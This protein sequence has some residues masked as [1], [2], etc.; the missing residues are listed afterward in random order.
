M[1]CKDCYEGKDTEIIQWASEKIAN[2]N[3]PIGKNLPLSGKTLK[4]LNS[5]ISFY[6]KKYGDVLLE[7]PEV[8]KIYYLSKKS[9][10]SEEALQ[11]LDYMISHSII[12]DKISNLLNNVSNNID[13]QQYMS[14]QHPNITNYKD[15][16]FDINV[17]PSYS[18]DVNGFTITITPSDEF[19]EYAKRKYPEIDSVWDQM[20]RTPHHFGYLAYARCAYQQGKNLV[21]NNL[22]R[23][24]DFDN[25]I[26]Q[27]GRLHASNKKREMAKWL[28]SMTKNW[29]V[30]LLH[31]VKSLAIKEDINAFL[32]TFDQ[33]KSKWYN[34]PVHK[35][36]KSYKE[37][38]E[39]MGFELNDADDAEHLVENRTGPADIMY[40]VANLFGN[41][42]K[43]AQ[44]ANPISI[45]SYNST[46]EL[47]ISFNGGKAYVYPNVSPFVYKKIQTLLR[48]KNYKKVQDMLKNL[49]ANNQET[50]EDRQQMLNQLYEDGHL[51]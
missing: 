19:F 41:W 13:A 24:A 5:F 7:R 16:P 45:I 49:S 4:N 22:Q 51:K 12:T 17:V 23:D 10:L 11:H 14:E 3:I 1:Y 2:L 33:Q 29:D 39:R 20:K 35:S 34:L 38:P 31:I 15:L 47:G 26:Q 32:T 28:D 25:Y 8:E 6:I 44:Q 18:H 48:V 21:I 43:K 46:G 27:V 37:V 36:M 50:E 9:G 40:Q 30:F 42:Y